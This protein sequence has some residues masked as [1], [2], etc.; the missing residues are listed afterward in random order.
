MKKIDATPLV[1]QVYAILQ[2]EI[3][4]R[5]L[6]PNEKLDI[7]KLAHQMNVSR[8]PVMEAL[9]QLEKDG[10]V[11]RR[12]RVGTFV[13]PLNRE[14]LI[15]SFEAREMVEQYATAA[16]IQNWVPADITRLRDKLE[17]SEALLQDVDEADFDYISYTT[18]D[19][20]FHV[21]LV[22]LAGN[23]R[24]ETFYRS[25]NSHMQIAR[26]FVWQAL[27]RAQEGLAEHREIL[28]AFAAKDIDTAR[29]QQQEHLERSRDAVLKIIDELGFL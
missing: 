28:D 15:A 14:V 6:K 20:D 3:V 21:G 16:A 8:T 10:L 24:I 5:N 25:L 1:E 26:V 17:A 18:Y 22:Q 12:N 11:I 7:N 29:K 2:Q 27:T 23:P 4:R 19:H 13:T 9:A